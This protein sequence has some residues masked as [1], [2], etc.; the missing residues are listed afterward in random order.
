MDEHGNRWPVL[1]TPAFGENRSTLYIYTL[2]PFEALAGL[3]PAVARLPAA[4]AGIATIG[5]LAW[6]GGLLFGPHVGTTGAVFLAM[7]PW[8]VFI[9]RFGVEASLTPFLILVA[10]GLALSA[11]RRPLLAMSAGIVAAGACYGYWAVRIFLPLFVIGVAWMTRSAWRSDLR[12]AKG[13]AAVALFVIAFVA[14]LAPLAWAHLTD[15]EDLAKRGLTGLAW[16][17]DDP[18]ETRLR[19]VAGRYLG[20]FGP[21]FLFLRGD[22]YPMHSLP[23]TGVFSWYLVPLILVGVGHLIRRFRESAPARIALAWVVLYPVA[24]LLKEHPG[25]HALRSL[26]GLPGLTLVAATGAVAIYGFLR[27]RWER[28]V[29]VVVASFALW[30]GVECGRFA[31]PFFG[32]YAR[33]TRRNVEFQADIL[34]AFRRLE[35]RLEDLEGIWCTTRGIHF[36]YVNAL[37]GLRYDP[38][39]WFREERRYDTGDEWNECIRFGKVR[40]MPY[41]ANRL[42]LVSLQQ[43]DRPDR[44]ALLLRPGELTLGPAARPEFTITSPEGMPTLEVYILEI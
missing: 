10:L 15:A 21:S 18:M 43:N 25:M 27:N 1:Y 14:V 4:C 44:V 6:V 8:H 35:N 37:V 31:V 9:S 38:D 13:R 24:D 41:E 20:H 28:A 19:N 39:R 30:V 33:D 22:P 40:I 5:L 36:P 42:D 17:P 34:E 11:R 7:N 12:S 29:P 2:L 16:A 23:R 26:P 32:D 3:G